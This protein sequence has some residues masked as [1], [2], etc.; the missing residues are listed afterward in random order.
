MSFQKAA[1]DR[2]WSLALSGDSP[3]R[4]QSVSARPSSE[5]VRQLSRDLHRTWWVKTEWPP[6]SSPALSPS[7][8]H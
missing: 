2:D 7:H 5:E 8:P 4:C 3:P 6:E 1:L